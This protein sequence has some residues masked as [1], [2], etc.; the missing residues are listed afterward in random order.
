MANKV[1]FVGGVFDT[2]LMLRKTADGS[3][4]AAGTCDGV[5]LGGTPAVGS[6]ARIAVPDAFTTTTLLVE[7]QVA[8]TDADGSYVTV[9]Q[10]ELITAAGEYAVRFASR[11]AY[12]R[13]KFTVAGTTPDFGAVQVG[14]TCGGF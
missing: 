12:A 2:D 14:V 8:D 4:T 3:L 1:K 9:A 6:V 7:I 11:R 5:A 10:S 13:A